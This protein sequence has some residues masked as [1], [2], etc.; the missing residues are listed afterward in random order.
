MGIKVTLKNSSPHI[1]NVLHSFY[2]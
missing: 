1:H 2:I